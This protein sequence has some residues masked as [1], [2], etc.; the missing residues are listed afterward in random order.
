MLRLV[1]AAAAIAGGVAST[2]APPAE[3]PT[4]DVQ[5]YCQEEAAG[6]A[7]RLNECIS[8]QQDAYDA[9]IR[10]WFKYGPETIAYCDKLVH[11]F[12]PLYDDLK[13]CLDTETSAADAP[14]SFAP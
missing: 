8:Y 4:Y 13:Y 5:T 10:D 1:V 14:S 12:T 11:T 3:I 7:V 9:L 2:Q 6:S